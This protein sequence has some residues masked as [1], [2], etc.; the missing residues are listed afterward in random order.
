VDLQGQLRA[1]KRLTGFIYL[2]EQ[3]DEAKI[4]GFGQRL[5]YIEPQKPAAGK[6]SLVAWIYVLKPVLR[7]AQNGDAGGRLLKHLVHSFALAHQLFGR[8]QGFGLYGR[9]ALIAGRVDET[10]HQPGPTTAG[11]YLEMVVKAIGLIL[12]AV[13]IRLS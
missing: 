6:K 5:R 3:R 9:H 8:C 11:G 7:A 10:D 4:H 12:Y 2:V 13:T 1:K